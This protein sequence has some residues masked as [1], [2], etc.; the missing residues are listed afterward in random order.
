MSN[1]KE[2]E[3]IK[4]RAFNLIICNFDVPDTYLQL[5]LALSGFHSCLFSVLDR[6]LA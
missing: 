5:L 6:D 3:T 2:L 4:Q 1:K